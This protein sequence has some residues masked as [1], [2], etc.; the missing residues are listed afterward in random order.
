MAAKETHEAI[1]SI[2]RRKRKNHWKEKWLDEEVCGTRVGDATCKINEDQ[3]L[4]IPCDKE[5]NFTS[6]GFITI[7]DHMKRPV[8]KQRVAALKNNSTFVKQLSRSYHQSW[9][10]LHPQRK[11]SVQVLTSD[12]FSAKKQ[13]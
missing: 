9:Y 4:C 13:N 8:H 3:A 11:G 5:I 7:V 2:L 10:L 6:R 1:D 12:C